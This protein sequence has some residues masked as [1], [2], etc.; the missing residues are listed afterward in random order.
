MKS[1]VP[2]LLAPAG[3]WPA[4][5]AA[6]A[7]GADAVYFGVDGFNARMRAANFQRSE[8]PAIADW[9]HRRGIKAYL[10]LNVLVFPAELQEAA[11]LVCAAADA[12][13]DALIVQDIGLALLARELAPELAIHASTQMSITSTAGVAQARATIA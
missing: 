6:A 3:H 1:G 10:T 12:G 8:L 13:I 5:E 4:M 7:N 9:L 11:E 2:E